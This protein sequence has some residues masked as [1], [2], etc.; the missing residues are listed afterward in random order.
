MYVCPYKYGGFV[1]ERKSSERGLPSSIR[2]LR[3]PSFDRR[4]KG[5]WDLPHFSPRNEEI[6]SRSSVETRETGMGPP[7]QDPGLEDAV[8]HREE[9]GSR[10]VRDDISVHGEGHGPQLRLQIH[11]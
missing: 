5:F 6:V 8:Y 7:V 1:G 9:A 11:S 4:E 2:P 10:A 3:P